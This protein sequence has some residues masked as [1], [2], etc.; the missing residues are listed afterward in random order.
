MTGPALV[1]PPIDIAGTVANAWS[2]HTRAVKSRA[3]GGQRTYVYASGWRACNRAMALDLL[4]PED[5]VYDDGTYERFYDGDDYELACRARLMKAGQ[6]A[7]PAFDVQGGQERFEVK[8]RAGRVIIV[9]KI[10]G[11][12]YWP[13]Y[14]LKVPF[15]IKS[16]RSVEN[17]HTFDDFDL[18]TWTRPM[19]RQLLTY[20]LAMNEAHGLFVLNRP[21]APKFLHVQLDDQ[22]LEMAE[23]FQQ[24]AELACDVREGKARMPDYTTNRGECTRCDH[25]GKTCTPDMDFGDG[26]RLVTDDRLIKLGKVVA[27]NEEAAKAYTKARKALAKDLKP[28]REPGQEMS[29]TLIHLGSAV[30][31]TGK[32]SR[33]TTF[34]VPTEVKEPFKEVDDHG[35]WTM[36]VRALELEVEAEARGARGF[37][38]TSEEGET[39]ASHLSWFPAGRGQEWVHASIPPTEQTHGWETNPRWVQRAKYDPSRE[40]GD[41]TVLLGERWAYGEV[42]VHRSAARQARLD[43]EAADG[44]Q[45][46]EGTT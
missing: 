22:T 3:P 45:V 2:A 38:I 31:V 21:G 5:S 12:V 4:Y 14:R 36:S 11:Y 27:K 44:Q 37:V 7:S 17:V 39:L 46:I 25:H 35:R 16:G 15:E 33:S 43:A 9:G 6:Q 34:K 19:P 30:E 18:S 42:T 13:A 20:M 8:D 28:A 23:G 41:H 29:E 1:T 10:D 24:V 26:L 32:W 40:P